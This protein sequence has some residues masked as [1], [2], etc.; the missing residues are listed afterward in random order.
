MGGLHYHLNNRKEIT[1]IKNKHF[2]DQKKYIDPTEPGTSERIIAK[3][4]L[5]I[6]SEGNEVKLKEGI[7]CFLKSA[8]KV[9]VSLATGNLNHRDFLRQLYLTDTWHGRA[10]EIEYEQ[11]KYFTHFQITFPIPDGDDEFN[12]LETLNE[13][14]ELLLGV[15]LQSGRPVDYYS[16]TFYLPF[17]CPEK[18]LTPSLKAQSPYQLESVLYSED[19]SQKMRGAFSEELQETKDEVQNEQEQNE[20]TEREIK[21]KKKRKEKQLKLAREAQAYYFFS[22]T[23]REQLFPKSKGKGLSI[24]R[25]KQNNS[26]G[27]GELSI[28]S[29][30]ACDISQVEMV[31]NKD[32]AIFSFT[33]TYDFYKETCKQFNKDNSWWLTLFED[34]NE[35][36]A[37]FLLLTEHV[38]Y[39]YPAFF[40]QKKRKKSVRSVTEMVSVWKKN[41]QREIP[42]F[43]TRQLKR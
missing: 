8:D 14:M 3:P 19:K 43:L 10:E 18:Q 37:D 12:K 39:L 2:L 31:I 42:L 35:L 1:T 29:G 38:R 20:K 25:V 40:K 11:G 23:V 9:T 7:T 34:K 33:L 4:L 5:I 21:A 24:W 22:P 16:T 15:V 26:N 13:F 32:I 27:L 36:L 17:Y 28:E 6:A 30:P 41:G